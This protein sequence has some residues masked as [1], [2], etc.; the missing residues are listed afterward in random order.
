MLLRPD[1]QA[2]TLW[3]ERHDLAGLTLEGVQELSRSS[4]VWRH[5][6][7]AGNLHNLTRRVLE[8]LSRNPFWE[9]SRPTLEGPNS[10]EIRKPAELTLLVSS[11]AR[12]AQRRRACGPFAGPRVRTPAT[13]EQR[14][15]GQHGKVVLTAPDEAQ[16]ALKKGLEALLTALEECRLGPEEGHTLI[17]TAPTAPSNP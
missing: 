2:G 17:K 15:S 14:S 6:S 10:R 1:A 4:P 11:S 8:T 12:H 16:M 7:S 5:S 3:L 9:H 13:G